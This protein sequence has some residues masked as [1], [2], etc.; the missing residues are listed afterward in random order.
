MLPTRLLRDVLH[1]DDDGE[2]EQ[3]IADLVGGLGSGVGPIT[4]HAVQVLIQHQ[5]RKILRGVAASSER[6]VESSE[7]LEELT[8]EIVRLTRWLKWLTIT[9]V[10]LTAALIVLES[11]PRL[12]G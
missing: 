3:T 5:E 2:I 6:L 9:L 10:A 7:H 8:Q 11:L 1:D 12:R 4:V